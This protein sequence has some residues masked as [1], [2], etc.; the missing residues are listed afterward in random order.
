MKEIEEKGQQ[1]F[2][3]T[4]VAKLFRTLDWKSIEDFNHLWDDARASYTFWN[5]NAYGMLFMK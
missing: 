1:Y 4:D 3:P 5:Q 2:G